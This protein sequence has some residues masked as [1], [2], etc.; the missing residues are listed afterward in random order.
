MKKICMIRLAI[1]RYSTWAIVLIGT[2]LLIA[3]SLGRPSD[4]QQ[5]T[6]EG[7]PSKKTN[8]SD[9]MS[10]PRP[11]PL[12]FDYDTLE[13][14]LAVPSTTKMALDH[15]AWDPLFR[16]VEYRHL[17]LNHP[18]LM[19]IHMV[20]IDLK[21][22]GLHFFATPARA[23]GKFYSMTVSNF[24]RTY[25]PL[26]AINASA[27]GPV[28]DREGDE[29]DLVGLSV[30]NGVKQSQYKVG[31]AYLT[32]S[33]ANHVN[34]NDGSVKPDLV[35]TETA[36]SGFSLILRDGVNLSSNG[37]E[38]INPRTAVGLSHDGRF[39]FF[40]AV[41]GR[42]PG[43]SMGATMSDLAQL[44]LLVGATTAI[45]LDGGGSTTMVKLGRDG[46]PHQMNI[47][48]EWGHPGQ[49]RPVANHLG[50]YVDEH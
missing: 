22:P 20:R 39:L 44:F 15:S 33:K 47:P 32:I 46:L 27:F 36:V 1:F 6:S 12:H 2:I 41:D 31:Y 18:R 28:T 13:T 23:N 25:H 48:I 42:Q 30:S 45:N 16:G 24:V 40:V 49:E 3:S 4:A 37:D 35:N 38:T 26:L 10:L 11:Q 14:Q 34:L 21:T 17:V 5:S 50:V 19:Q 8:S 9:G 7:I 43:Y 29:Q